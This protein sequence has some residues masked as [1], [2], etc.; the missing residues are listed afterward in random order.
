[1][2]AHWLIGS[3]S[4]HTL[5]RCHSFFSVGSALSC[6]SRSDPERL[7]PEMALSKAWRCVRGVW[8]VAAILLCIGAFICF[9][10][11]E[12]DV[13]TVLTP[14]HSSPLDRGADEGYLAITHEAWEADKVPVNADLLTMVVL[15]V[16]AL[17]GL[18]FGWV[19]T[20]TQKQ[21]ALF[22][23]GVVGPSLASACEELSFLEV[24]R[25]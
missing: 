17:F 8:L 5:D 6:G 11:A 25:Q 20:N 18:S 4:D 14:T 9:L 16:S 10:P 23:W 3:C 21:G 12:L 1:M 22:S 24:F 7:Q 19:L 13:S 15:G 2:S